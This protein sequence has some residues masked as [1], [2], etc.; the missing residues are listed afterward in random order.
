MTMSDSV[1]F[2]AWKQPVFLARQEQ[3]GSG[4]SK[5][6]SVRN[7]LIELWHRAAPH[8]PVELTV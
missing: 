7:L 1:F 3:R 6:L 5:R 2:V 4:R 8:R